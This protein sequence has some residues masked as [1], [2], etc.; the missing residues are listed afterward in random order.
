[1]PMGEED[2]GYISSTN[3]RSCY[4]ESKKC[5][6]NLAVCYGS[7]YGIDVTIG[8]L[9][10]IY[11]AGMSPEDSKICAEMVRNVADGADIVLKTPGS[12]RRSYT[13][14]SDAVTGLLTVL[15]KGEPGQS[16]N[17]GSPDSA[18]SIADMA[19]LCCGL[20][21]EKGAQVRFDIS[22]EPE[23]QA[24]SFI[25]DAV[26]DSGKLRRLGWYSAVSLEKGL[27]RAVLDAQ[28]E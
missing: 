28:S 27:R 13:Y 12:Q 22:C 4:P 10:Y 1:M 23:K 18:V 3:V 2:Y 15:L 19:R 16:Y 26:M 20:F 14:I 21:P 24:F 11:G 7:Q 5:C 8:R 6:E 9:S 17:I 25:A